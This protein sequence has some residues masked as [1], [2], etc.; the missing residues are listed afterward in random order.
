MAGEIPPSA[1]IVIVGGGHNGL[2]AAAY[3]AQAGLSVV[4]LERQ[5]HWGGAAVSAQTFPGVDA[6]LSRYSYLVSLLPQTII[7]DLGLDITLVKRRYS[8]FTPVPGGDTGLLIDNYDDE[9]TLASFAA[10]GATDDAQAWNDLYAD[11][12]TLA[13]ALF[14]TV[15]DPLLTRSEA[16]SLVASRPGGARAWE[17]FIDTP[18]GDTIEN[19]LSNDVVR[20]VVLTDALIGTFA[21][22]HDQHWDA[23][24]CFLYHV[25]GGSTGDWDVPVGGMGAVSGALLGAAR[26][27]GARLFTD[28]EVTSITDDRVV[29]VTRDGVEH[30]IAARFVL[31]NASPHELARLRGET[32]GPLPEGAQVKVNMV[33]SRLPQLRDP[34]VTPEQAFGGTFHINETWSQLDS[35][36]ER[37]AQGRI[38]EP[39]P[40]EIYCHTLSDPSILSPELAEQGVHTLTVFGLHVPHRLVGHYD[41]DELRGLLQ[42]AVLDSLNSVLGEPIEPLLLLDSEGNACIETKTTADL[43]HAL[44]LPGGNIF[45]GPLEWPFAEDTDDLSSPAHRWGVATS[46]EGV[47]MCG[48][49]ARRGGAVSGIAGHNAAMAVLEILGS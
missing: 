35:A 5:D 22:N 41:N 44:G 14:P 11:T 38:P 36:F 20:G 49:G 47:L 12:V 26:D 2:T 46:T 33:L 24:K 39:L 10:L 42:K 45:H 23:N 40:C 34:S 6:R 7:D 3:L 4:V 19:V 32:P 21:P 9:A 28:A 15:T 8:S 30:S 29:E 37:A 16:Q 27:A 48:A 13:G 31:V 18:V 17:R 1:D 25:I 43:E